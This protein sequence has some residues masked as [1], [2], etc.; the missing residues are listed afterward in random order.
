MNALLTLLS[1]YIKTFGAILLNNGGHCTFSKMPNNMAAAQKILQATDTK[2][3][4]EFVACPK[5]HSIYNYDDCIYTHCGKKEAKTCRHVAHPNHPCT[6][7]RIA[8]STSLLKKVKTIR[9][10]KFIPI[11][12]YPYQPLSNSLNNL[13]RKGDFLDSCEKWRSRIIPETHLADIY[14][15]RVWLE[16]KLNGFLMAP[17]CYLVTLNLDW[18]QPFTHI[19]YSVGVIYLAVQ[20]LPRSE[21]YKV[22]NIILVG[23]L[24][25]PSEPKLN[26]NSYLA[27]LVEDLKIAWNKGI[28]VTTRNGL[29]ITVR[30]ALTCVACDI[31]ASRKICGFLGHNASLG[32]NKCLKLFSTPSFGVMDYSGYDRDTWTFRSGQAHR[33]N[34]RKLLTETTKTGLS[35]LESKLG[36][37]YSVLLTLPYFDPVRFTVVD[38]MH[39][40]FLGTGKYMFKLWISLNLLTKNDLAAIE[41]IISLYSVPHY[42]GRLPIN[43]SSN[44]GGYTA[45]QWQKWI[46]L[47]SPV[48][49]KTILPNEHYCCWLLF[50]RAC[51][52][53]SRQIVSKNDVL[54]ADMLLLNFCKKF[55]LLYGKESCTP[56]L[57]LHNHLKDC[58]LDYGPSHTFW[59]FSFE[60]L[61]GVLG[62]FHT[63]RKAIEPQ[64]MKKFINTQN[65]QGIQHK[66]NSQVLSLFLHEPTSCTSSFNNEDDDYSNLFNSSLLPL[67][68]N[69]ISLLLKFNKN[70]TM[71]PPIHEDIFSADLLKDLNLFYSMIYPDFTI[72]SATP[73]FVR[74]G[75]V[76]VCKQLIGSTMNS[77]C[78][79][80]SSVVCAYWPVG[81]C[82]MSSV[83]YSARMRIGTVQYF[84]KHQ[85][86][87]CL[88][89]SNQYNQEH[90]L[91]YI[92]WNQ[93]HS[94]ENWYGISATV[95]SNM[96]EPATACSFI[97]VQRIHS[98]CAYCSLYTEI[99][100]L[101]ENIV[102]AIPIPISS[103]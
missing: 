85:V 29:C 25:G 67:N 93:R 41:N 47:Y 30:L 77:R 16:Y 2:S 11:K 3:F 32:C 37:R 81:D 92:K 75:R 84:C 90:I 103:C 14:D 17:F 46:T 70:V 80:S 10:F 7:Q 61:N 59:C 73:F 19:E 5:C 72:E 26:I 12:V 68:P 96:Y 24:P 82:D 21:R 55:E 100:T 91:A 51:S 36:V 13:A 22:E 35:R 39:N 52:I 86:T 60:R 53:L 31:P 18:F 42:L 20:N 87:L 99:A 9:G 58:L 44:Y 15:G 45:A 97:P 65:L 78:S 88:P 34:C 66:A 76:T 50:V 64:I 102:V 95:C 4:I 101:R 57:H 62:S 54:V 49:L 74:C 43:I 8:C 40:L 33:E 89:N 56:N 79:N 69:T 6:S 71:L 27:P 28:Q 38:V 83:N 98:V 94:E 48:A 63:N 1:A 23:I